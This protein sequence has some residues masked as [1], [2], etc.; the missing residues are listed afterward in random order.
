[1]TSA[2]LGI[3]YFLWRRG[4]V[5]A[6]IGLTYVLMLAV[7]LRVGPAEVGPAVALLALGPLVFVM[8]QLLAVLVMETPDALTRSTGYPSHLLTLPA[9]TA[10]LVGWPM[11]YMALLVAVAMTLV[12]CA[13]KVAP[14]PLSV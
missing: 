13:L 4:R 6:C 1:M 11:L 5:P 3:G 7:A 12:T 10:A 8:F 14:E 2:G 9:T